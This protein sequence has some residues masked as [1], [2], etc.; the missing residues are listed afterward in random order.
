MIHRLFAASIVVV[1]FTGTAFG[2]F[3]VG[4]I[5]MSSPQ[6][7]L[8]GDNSLINII[9]QSSLSAAYRN[10]VTNFGTYM[11]TT[12][13]SGFPGNGFTATADFGPQQFTFDLGALTTIN[14]IAIWNTGFRTGAVNSFSVF[15]DDDADFGNGTTGMLLGATP[16]AFPSNPV[17]AQTFSFDATTTRFVHIEGLAT[18]DPPDLYALGEV[19]FSGVPAP[20]TCVWDLD[21][22]E[23]V[24][25]GDLIVLLGSWGD[26]YGTADL[27]ELL[28]NWGPCPK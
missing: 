27:I 8:G 15:S 7:D 18:N 22:D 20:D 12:T 28:G 23:T 11:A 13:H 14:G 1:V 9:N 3:V 5:S 6:G 17:P 10:G 2:D 19:A 16:L 24:G 21:D 4:A 26:P 25:T